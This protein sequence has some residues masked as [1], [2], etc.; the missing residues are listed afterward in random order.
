M[1]NT[2]DFPQMVRAYIDARDMT[3]R[4]FSVLVGISEVQ[5]SLILNG[6]AQASGPTI[7]KVWPIIHAPTPNKPPEAA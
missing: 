5:L 2:F 7:A 6:K 1:N 3:Q 4:E